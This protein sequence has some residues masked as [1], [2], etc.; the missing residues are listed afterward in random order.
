MEIEKI[1]IVPLFAE[2]R[3]TRIIELLHENTKLVV[4]QLC[5]YFN[6]SPATIRN[7]LR[8]LENE[9]MLTRTHGGA[10]RNSK[11]SFELNYYQKEIENYEKK[12]AIAKLAI[13]LVDDG[14]TIAIDTG[15]TTLELAKLLWEKKDVTAVVND[16]ELARYLEKNSSV[17]IIMIG[18]N[19]RRNF[20]CA[21]GPIAIRALDGL[22]V[23]KAFMATNG[24]SVKKG[25]STPDINQAEV[26][27]AMLDIASEIIVLCDSTKIGSHAFV[28][29]APISKVN[30]LITDNAIDS[31]DLKEF[32][33]AGV[34]VDIA[35]VVEV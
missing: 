26:K 2:E 28:K 11:T 7:D 21:V 25:I 8:E 23:D 29:V 6:V 27:K 15:T 13:G 3:K 34:E 35:D 19:I 32:E 22:N 12:L 16:I 20:H 30:R 33:T 9:G 18:G 14:D 4:P 17:N 5:V 1:R 24:I 31:N 10:I